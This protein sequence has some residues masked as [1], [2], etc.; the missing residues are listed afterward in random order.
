MT[1]SRL[2]SWPG[3][4]LMLVVG[5]TFLVVGATRGDGPRTQGDRVDDLTQRIACPVCDGESVFVSQNN[6][7]RALRNQV[8]ELVRANELSD[9]EI[10]A[11]IDGRNE[12]ELLLVPRSSG[13]DALVWVLPALGL[14]VGV[15][16]LS[17]TFRRWR[18]EAAGVGDPTAA[19]RELVASALSDSDH[20]AGRDV[21]RPRG[22]PDPADVAT[23]PGSDRGATPASGSRAAPGVPPGDPGG[24]HAPDGRA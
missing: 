10:L 9:D 5:V 14:V 7:S 22:W 3:W 8:E 19:D 1:R 11:V 4:A 16:G 18:V 23:D 15:V 20:E 12:A 17:V 24:A 13:L 6:A 2:R 21:A